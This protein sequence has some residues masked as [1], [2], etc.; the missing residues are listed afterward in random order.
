M[1]TIIKQTAKYRKKLIQLPIGIPDVVPKKTWRKKKL[2]NKTN[3]YT[4]TITEL[5]TVERS[6]QTKREKTKT[7]TPP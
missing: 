2:H 1:N 7:T 6:K 5:L 3:V 4:L